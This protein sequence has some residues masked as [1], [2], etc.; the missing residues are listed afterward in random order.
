MKKE[1]NKLDATHDVVK[2]PAPKG[3]MKRPNKPLKIDPNKGKKTV[4]K[5]MLKKENT[6]G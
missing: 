3:P 2:I 1:I 4:S 5:Y 6:N